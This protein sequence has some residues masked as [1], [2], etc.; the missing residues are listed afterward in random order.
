MYSEDSQLSIRCL[1]AHWC[2]N[3]LNNWNTTNTTTK[4]LAGFFYEL[5]IEKFLIVTHFA[6]FMAVYIE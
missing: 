5:K 1:Y 4:E 3:L 2:F 6:S